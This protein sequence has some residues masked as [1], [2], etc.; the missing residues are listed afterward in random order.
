MTEPQAAAKARRATATAAAIAA[1]YAAARAEALRR[2]AAGS[3]RG[4]LDWKWREQLQR[5]VRRESLE[6]VRTI[7][8]LV[9]EDFDLKFWTPNRAAAVA[10]EYLTVMAREMSDAWEQLTEEALASI[11]LA[12]ANIEAEITAAMRTGENL[13]GV[14]GENVTT[15]AANLAAMDAAKAAGRSTKTWHLGST[16]E[17]RASHAAQSGK[18]IGIDARFPNGQRFPGSP[19]PPAERLN[20]ECYLTFGG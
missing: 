8:P 1:V 10:D 20:C 13:S 3:I 11:D 7:G 16:T 5:V 14:D 4:A 12:T 2:G 15:S 9:A 6:T 18:T 17:H 19:A